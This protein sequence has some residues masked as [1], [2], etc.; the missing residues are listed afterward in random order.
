M[1]RRE[2]RE[3]RRRAITCSETIRS[4]TKSICSL[5]SA[6][7][8]PAA[9]RTF[10]TK[11]MLSTD[12]LTMKLTV[13]GKTHYWFVTT[14]NNSV[15]TFRLVNRVTC[16]DLLLRVCWWF[17][18]ERIHVQLWIKSSNLELVIEQASHNSVSW[19][20]AETRRWRATLWNSHN[21]L[22]HWLVHPNYPGKVRFTPES[23][24]RG[25][26][27]TQCINKRHWKVCVLKNWGKNEERK[28][29]LGISR[30]GGCS[31]WLVVKLRMISS[32]NEPKKRRAQSNY[33]SNRISTSTCKTGS[34]V[35]NRLN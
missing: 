5:S 4:P 35:G 29:S 1:S 18:T 10:N 20:W 14:S 31:N 8:K 6:N 22:V 19:T 27:G 13:L 32:F 28:H 26:N 30:R 7:V 12:R 33:E 17:L 11:R 15:G 3:N 16:S 2:W 24:V 9:F 34:V 23:I 21:A 25:H